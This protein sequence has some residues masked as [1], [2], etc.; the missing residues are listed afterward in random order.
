MKLKLIAA[1]ILALASTAT[2]AAPDAGS[3]WTVFIR[4]AH[5]SLANDTNTAL[6]GL[7]VENKTIP[8]I[9][10]R[11]SFSKN[12]AAELLLTVPQKHNVSLNGVD[13]GSFKHLPPTLFGQYHFDTESNFKPY[14]GAG[15]NYTRISSVKL[16]GGAGDLDNSSVGAAAQIGCDY[17]LSNNGYIS[18]DLKKI[19]ISSDVKVAGA[20]VGSIDLDPTVF[21]VGYGFS[22]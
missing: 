4:A 7:E 13:I 15:I 3:P 9:S 22:F 1:S 5:L 14:I 20:K 12:W 19:Y 10:I 2:F 11:Y 17:K 16:L 6:N 18:V 21:A 8:D